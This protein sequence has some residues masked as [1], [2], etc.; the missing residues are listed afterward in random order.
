VRNIAGGKHNNDSSYDAGMPGADASWS[1]WRAYFDL[2]VGA[3]AQW[4][5]HAAFEGQYS[6][7]TLI[8]GEQFSLGGAR[9]VRGFPERESSGDRGWR[10]SGELISPLV[11]GQHRLLGFIDSGRLAKVNPDAAEQ[12]SEALLST[13]LGWRWNW[14]ST[15][16][17][18]LD[19]AQVL[20]GTP[21]TG[22][23][24]QAVHIS[25]LWRFI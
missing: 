19:W 14:R 23:G 7:H 18:T 25:A 20:N 3:P 6:R 24:H 10:F 16:F 8:S 2:H 11:S 9:S 12:R 15:V 1:A 5:L 17:T 21:G 4:G 13:G 22:R